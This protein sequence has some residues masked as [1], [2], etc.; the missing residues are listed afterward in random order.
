MCLIII[1]FSVLLQPTPAERVQSTL[2]NL[3]AFDEILGIAP[4]NWSAYFI[5]I[6]ESYGTG[7]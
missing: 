7:E 2:D 1:I 3:A 5:H 4:T 6:I